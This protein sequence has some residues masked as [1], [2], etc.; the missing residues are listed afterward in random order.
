MQLTQVKRKITEMKR[1]FIKVQMNNKKVDT[2]SDVTLIKEQTWKRMGRPT[3]IK[4]KK[5][6]RGITRNR[7]KFVD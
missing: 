2:G 6:A 4:T 7:L 5:I 3:L 1:K